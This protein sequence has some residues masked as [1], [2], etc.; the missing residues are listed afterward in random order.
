MAGA[1]VM[2]SEVTA[3]KAFLSLSRQRS[4]E[5]HGQTGGN[6]KALFPGTS[7]GMS[8]LDR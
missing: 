2:P 3:A 7:P 5:P 1:A 8:H 4:P 6:Q